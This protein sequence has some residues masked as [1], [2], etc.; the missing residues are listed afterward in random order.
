LDLGKT[1]ANSLASLLSTPFHAPTLEE[2]KQNPGYQFA[3]ESG[4]TAL[5][6][7]AAARGDVFSGTQGTALQEYGQR[8]GEQNYN[9]VY[10]RA[11]NDY[12]TRYNTLLGGTQVG[13]TATGQYG[14]EGQAAATGVAGI[15]LTGAKMQAEQINNA[16]A[17]R[18]SGYYQS[19]NAWRGALSGADQHLGAGLANM[20]QNGVPWWV[21]M[22]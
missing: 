14:Q 6:K 22:A 11:M 1:S 9:D 7:S 20:Y 16:A 21:A 8:L 4:T 3:L 17:A 15:D 18:A 5:D 2:A 12:M 19:A 13:Q 10:A